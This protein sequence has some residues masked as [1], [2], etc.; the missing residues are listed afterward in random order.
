MQEHSKTLPEAPKKVVKPIPD[1][2]QDLEELGNPK[3]LG[4]PKDPLS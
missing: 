1:E 4:N 2:Q 3:N